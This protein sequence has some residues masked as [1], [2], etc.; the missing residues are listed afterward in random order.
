MDSYLLRYE[1]LNGTVW[2]NGAY[3]LC[4]KYTYRRTQHADSQNCVCI[5]E[6]AKNWNP[7]LLLTIHT[8]TLLLSNE[9]SRDE[10]SRVRVVF[11]PRIEKKPRISFSPVVI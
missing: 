7:L 10:S 8:Y 6:E 9:L 11:A 1:S 5:S 2:L 3:S 4:R